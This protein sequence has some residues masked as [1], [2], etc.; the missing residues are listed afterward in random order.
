MGQ[1]QLISFARAVLA[2]PAI[3]LLDEA[4]ANMDSYSEQVLQEALKH[5]LKGRT[6]I[7]IAHRLSTILAA[8]VILV[9]DEGQV[10]EQGT[11]TEL[12]AQDGL[13]ARLYHT[14]FSSQPTVASSQTKPTTDD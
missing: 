6:A 2:D 8:D 5:L 10:I 1:R 11:H 7:V 3:L 4:T 12:L 13:Y 9:I 14:Q